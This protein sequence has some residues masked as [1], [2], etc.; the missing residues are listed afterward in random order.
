MQRPKF[1]IKET[2]MSPD[3]A[4]S[5][6]AIANFT[7]GD[8]Q[9]RITAN[10]VPDSVTDDELALA[11]EITTHQI[12]QELKTLSTIEMDYASN[13][14]TP[15]EFLAL[16]YIE[17]QD[18]STAIIGRLKRGDKLVWCLVATGPCYCPKH[19]GTEQTWDVHHGLVKDFGLQLS[20]EEE[21]AA[22]K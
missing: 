17:L 16:V 20:W 1:R 18:G 2:L 4:T 5:E 12:G 21:P 15:L 13:A 3:R 7:I 19:K 10:P 22:T 8:Q 14:A 6:E 11:N 9:V